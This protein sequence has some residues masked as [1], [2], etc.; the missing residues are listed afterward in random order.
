MTIATVITA[1]QGVNAGIAGITSAPTTIP[2]SLNTADLPMMLCFV[3]PGEPER[4]SDFSLH[5]RTFYIRCYVKPISR[6]IG[7]D[8]GYSEAYGLLQSVIEEYLSDITFGGAVQHTGT[9]A[10]Y[11]PPTMEDSGIQ[12]MEYAGTLYHGFEIVI[13][14]KEQIT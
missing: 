5:F 2:G 7:P 13:T 10:R 6:D 14:T 4:V 9:G 12:A 1:V 3:G 11:D 8:A